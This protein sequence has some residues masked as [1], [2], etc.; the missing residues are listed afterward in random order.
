[1]AP[2]NLTVRNRSQALP[3]KQFLTRRAQP[4]AMQI[5]KRT[6]GWLPKPSTWEYQQALNAKRRAQAEA[7]I[8]DQSAL[9]TGIFG[10]QD[11]ASAGFVDL[12]IKAAIARLT[13][14]TA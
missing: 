3:R 7:Y 5:E 1:M 13:N 11:T 12:S 8:A 10:A 9:A 6:M 4:L 14:K 2:V